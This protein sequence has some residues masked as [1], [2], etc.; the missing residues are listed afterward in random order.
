MSPIPLPVHALTPGL[1]PGRAK[2]I[3]EPNY[4]TANV[5]TGIKDHSP[6]FQLFEKVEKFPYLME[7]IPGGPGHN[8]GINRRKTGK[9]RFKRMDESAISALPL[10]PRWTANMEN[11]I[12][13][14][15]R[16]FQTYFYTGNLPGIS[17]VV[18]LL[19]H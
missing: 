6:S 5:V 1:K 17:F 7:G 9:G 12:T 13:T 2:K 19:W 11:T 14:A 18:Q 16:L 4:R 3:P 15:Y 10:F 8:E